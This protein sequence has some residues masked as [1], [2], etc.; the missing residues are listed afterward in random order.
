MNEL[1]F[2]RH[3][4]FDWIVRSEGVWKDPQVDIEAI[5]KDVRDELRSSLDLLKRR[6]GPEC[7][8]GMVLVGGGGSGK[9]HLLQWL[10]QFTFQQQ[11][12][13]FLFADMTGVRDFW[14]T[15]QL[16]AIASIDQQLS[17]GYR[18]CQHILTGLVNSVI[19]RPR[20]RPIVLADRLAKW[21]V[22]QM[23]DLARRLIAHLKRRHRVQMTKHQDVLRALIM[24]MSDDIDLN[25][26]AN[27]WLHG[28]ETDEELLRRFAFTSKE[29]ASI[30]IVQGVSWLLSLR[31]PTVLAIDQMDSLVAQQLARFKNAGEQ[32]DAILQDD[33]EARRLK[34]ITQSVAGGLASLVQT[35][36]HR[37]LV[38]VSC[39]N[40]TWEHFRSEPLRSES[41][42]FQNPIPLSGIW[43]GQDARDLVAKRLEAAAERLNFKLPSPGWFIGPEAFEG[44]SGLS[45]REVLQKCEQH[46]RECLKQGRVEPLITL[47][48]PEVEGKV[49]KASDA[50]SD[51]TV[52]SPLDQEFANFK[53]SADIGPCMDKD[54]DDRVWP[55]LL[56]SAFRG[57]VH[58][59][60]IPPEVDM[61]VDDS[62]AGRKTYR[63]LHARFK[64]IDHQRQGHEQQF[65]FRVL[66]HDNPIAFQTRL[67]AASGDAGVDRR[68]AFRS[69]TI[70]R[71]N[72]P[73]G[74]PKTQQLVS[75]FNQMGGRWSPV[76]EDE[77][78]TLFAIRGLIESHGSEA[79]DWIRQ[80]RVVSEIGFIQT[81]GLVD[82][83]EAVCEVRARTDARIPKSE[84]KP[85]LPS[86]TSRP[87]DGGL[88]FGVRETAGR[89]TGSPVVVPW[90]NLTRH[91]LVIAGSGSGKTN[92]L[93]RI[94]EEAAIAG[95][96]SIVVD[97]N[98]DLIG[99]GEKRPQEAIPEQWTDD[100]RAKERRYTAARQVIVWTPNRQGANPIALRLVPNFELLADDSDELTVVVNVICNNLERVAAP[101]NSA[102]S[103]KMKGVLSLVVKYFAEHGGDS[104]EQLIEMLRELPSDVDTGIA[105]EIKLAGEMA[106]LLQA[107]LNSTPL[108]NAEGTPLDPARLL[109]LDSALTQTRISILSMVGLPERDMQQ[110]FLNQLAIELFTWIKRNPAPD[111]TLRGL[112]V[113]DEAKEFVPSGQSSVCKETLIRLVAQARKF[114]LGVIFAAQAPKD[115]DHRILN[116][117]F[118]QLF[119]QVNSPA[120]VKAVKDLLTQKRASDPG[121]IA[122]LNKGQF[123]FHNGEVDDRAFRI[124]TP[125]CLSHHGS[126]MTE[127]QVLERAT[128]SRKATA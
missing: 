114:G 128:A 61:V 18:Q 73:P 14:E 74:G 101:G 88:C 31:G 47:G 70:I 48:A 119:G 40:Q 60:P 105:D 95:I 54:A 45:P 10:R 102:K 3:L 39:Y 19:E 23:V 2:L 13:T 92:L 25:N 17:D 93:K 16:Q 111:G 79:F 11:A 123:F 118:T 112:L 78:R 122:R 87:V 99:L 68:L 38:V 4:D 113:I 46:R 62:L 120:A 35:V 72:D 33:D 96:P 8:L 100:D 90:V 63:Y 81:S 67:K 7:P 51:V 21:S 117:C 77:I 22:D 94:V 66:L 43:T 59:Y 104:I 109:G 27:A 12:V 126:P 89:A 49:K 110:S 34:A 20:D 52:G 76:S 44:T 121:S 125:Q 15:M 53:Q 124:R 75:Q 85:P 116:N 41:D 84:R 69:L 50:E 1:K 82:A 86:P 65:C 42:R 80:R 97:C 37:T 55:D 6:E 57:L 58:E 32:E 91:T 30:D 71:N 26:A 29:R 24:L 115:I 36:M 107:K 127:E 106:D 83:I 5:N 9:T 108:W 28:T 98:N 56:V 103:Q 64:I